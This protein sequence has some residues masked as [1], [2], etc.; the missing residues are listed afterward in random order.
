[1]AILCEIC[2]KEFKSIRA[3]G[4]HAKNCTPSEKKLSNGTFKCPYCPFL[5]YNNSQVL[6]RHINTVHSGKY[7]DN[8][9]IQNDAIKKKVVKR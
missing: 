5:K 9:L 2:G 8:K 7:D 4:F 3:L 1:M 6:S